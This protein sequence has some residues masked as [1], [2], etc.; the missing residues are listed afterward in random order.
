MYKRQ[1]VGNIAWEVV[2]NIDGLSVLI[3]SV[4]DVR[5]GGIAGAAAPTDDITLGNRLPCGHIPIAHVAIQGG[6]AVAVRDHHTDAV[7]PVP[8][9]LD[10]RAGVSRQH[11]R[12]VGCVNVRTVVPLPAVIGAP[13]VAIGAGD[14]AGIISGPDV[15]ACAAAIIPT[16]AAAVIVLLLLLADQLLNAGLVRLRLI[17]QR[18]VAG[19]RVFILPNQC[20]GLVNLLLQLL[21]GAGQLRPLLVQ[22]CFCL[23]YTS[24]AADD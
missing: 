6:D 24:D 7:A 19:L 5:P 1:I 3:H 21:L 22:G 16:T 13:A 12:A 17:Q 4:M 9:G 2:H 20:V 8:P 14:H 18:L 23:L 11:R 15:A 10:H